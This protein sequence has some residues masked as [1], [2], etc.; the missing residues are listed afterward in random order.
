MAEPVTN[1]DNQPVIDSTATEGNRIYKPEDRGY[2]ESEVSTLEALQKV[3]QGPAP[4]NILSSPET[5]EPNQQ[6]IPSNIS[7]VKVDTLPV[8]GYETVKDLADQAF[9]AGDVA[10]ISNYTKNIIDYSAEQMNKMP[11]Q[12]PNN[13][14]HSDVPG[15]ATGNYNPFQENTGMYLSLIH[16]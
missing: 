11:F 12:P 6:T 16:I 13:N 7:D 5:I 10:P 14:L 2:Q 3:N 4:T 15:K 8:P 1:K 9:A